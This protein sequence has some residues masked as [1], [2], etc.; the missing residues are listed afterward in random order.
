LFAESKKQRM[1]PSSGTKNG[2]EDDECMFD[3]D[4]SLPEI[5]DAPSTPVEQRKFAA[6][7]I[8]QNDSVKA[9]IIISILGHVKFLVPLILQMF[10]VVYRN[11][12]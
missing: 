12:N 3:S 10:I 9:V 7:Q 1:D 2:K 4:S 5:P 6:E 8:F 11:N